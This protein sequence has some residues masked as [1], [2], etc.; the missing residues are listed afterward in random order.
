MTRDGEAVD[1]V[2]RSSRDVVVRTSKSE[3]RTK[4]LIGADGA[5]S[6]VRGILGFQR[7]AR[8]MVALETLV[9]LS[10]TNI[11]NF[12]DDMAI[13]D[14]SLTSRGLLVG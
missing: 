6:T 8:L 9:P 1:P 10:C 5:N 14:V 4:V 13:F 3:Y 12:S 11:G 7:G 2:I